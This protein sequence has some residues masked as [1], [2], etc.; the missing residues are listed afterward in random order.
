MNIGLVKYSE[1]FIS[2][3][4][5]SVKPLDKACFKRKLRPRFKVLSDM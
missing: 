3:S 2:M 5:G 4:R 1:N